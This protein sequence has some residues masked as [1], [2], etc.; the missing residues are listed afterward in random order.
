M[1]L[2]RVCRSSPEYGAEIRRRNRHVLQVGDEIFCELR[3]H[4]WH[5]TFENPH[6]AR[7]RSEGQLYIRCGASVYC[8]GQ[9]G[10]PSANLARH[11]GT[12]GPCL[13]C[14]DAGSMCEQHPTR[15]W[16]HGVYVDEETG[17]AGPG[18]PCPDCNAIEPPWVLDGWESLAPVEDT[19]YSVE[20]DL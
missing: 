14:G 4:Q 3:C 8:A 1:P 9:V 11:P 16:P 7:N 13:T 17:C 6:A 12:P 5:A 10:T 18:V 19:C 15:P 20:K 2:L